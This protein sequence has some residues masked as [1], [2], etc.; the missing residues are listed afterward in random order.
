MKKG[1]WVYIMTN[2]PGG[3]L[4]IGVTSDLIRRASEHRQGELGGFTY[5]YWL[6]QLV[7]FEQYE[8]ILDAIAREK[9]IKKWHRAWKVALIEKEN[10]GWND[11]YERIL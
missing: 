6:K 10:P 8:D 4:Y 1:G 5:R 3:V 9:E 7:Y 2:R 11:L